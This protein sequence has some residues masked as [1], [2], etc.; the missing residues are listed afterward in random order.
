MP[1][2][3]IGYAYIKR[4]REIA[5][6]MIRHGF[7]YIVD[8]IGLRPFRSLREKLLGPRPLREHVLILSEAERLRLAF[9]EL[10]P[11]FIKFGQILSTR[12][13]LIPVEHIKE[14]SKLQDRVPAF[15]YSEVEKSIEKELGKRIEEIFL[16]FDPE[17][18]AAASIGQVH[19]A[20][21]AGGEE[22]AVKVMR[23]GIEKVIEIDLF[24]LM[25]LA[26]FIEKHIKDSKFFN[27]VGFMEE[28]SR[29]MRLEIDY[30]HE[31]QNA[32][33]FYLNFR[34]SSTVLIPK[35]YWEYTTKRVLTL[36][37]LEGIKISDIVQLEAAG[38]ER[39]RISTNLADA[40]LKM[41]F[42]DGFYHA[43]PH[44][45]NLFVSSDGVI[46]FFDFGMAGY[47]D[48][49]LRE[50]LFNLIIATLR[51]DMELLIDTL[52]VMG[53]IYDSGSG[54]T[55]LR[56]NLE[57]FINRYYS[58][59]SKYLDPTAFLR[60]LINVLI[61]SGGKIPTNIMLLS[62][63]L[64]MRDEI[65]RELDPS[66]NFGELVEPYVRKVLD[67]RAKA[68]YKIKE[69]EKMVRDF[70]NL[71]KVFPEKVNHIL[72]KAEKGTLKLE[73]QYPGIDNLAEEI[74]IT[75]NRLSFSMIISALIIGSSF[76]IQTEMS[77]R[78][79]G[80]PLLGIFGFLIAGFLGLGLLISIL[81]S[82]RW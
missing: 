23:P 44:P 55:I 32:D 5:D 43:D 58:L 42:E 28:F 72:R 80:V 35:V 71:I 63:T 50:N 15:E 74:D 54:G 31:A 61:K 21:L 3:N 11:T 37:F 79:F 10:G 13:D 69:A 51:Y 47:I 6:V 8:R 34:G 22:V 56:L 20:K 26:R 17:P 70:L 19:Y 53:L 7:G 18:I 77:P 9:E 59:E 48:P 2:L 57:E 49:V 33:K 14:L 41:L 81:H 12:H 68:S 67:E 1:L 46:I 39:K 62:K 52:E 78:L 82:G 36:E 64:I 60:D 65:S 40:Y 16:S 27:P 45:G 76:I 73:I 66:H 29:T 24:I 4:Y 75:S 30:T 38:L 25:N